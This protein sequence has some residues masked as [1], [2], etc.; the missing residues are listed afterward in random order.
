[1]D[2]TIEIPGGTYS[3]LSHLQEQED[4]PLD[5]IIRAALLARARILVS[6]RPL[7]GAPMLS[8][9]E[10]GFEGCGGDLSRFCCA[11]CNHRWIMGDDESYRC[12]VCWAY[13]GDHH[14]AWSRPL[15]HDDIEHDESCRSSLLG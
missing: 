12:P 14:L 1:M 9:E 5:D 7:S 15:D 3:L 11:M 10:A 2:R 4:R 8:P 6:E 13:E